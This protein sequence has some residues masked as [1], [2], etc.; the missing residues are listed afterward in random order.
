LYRTPE[1]SNSN[2]TPLPSTPL[3]SATITFIIHL[4]YCRYNAPKMLL[5]MPAL[6]SGMNTDFGVVV[7][8]VVVIGSFSYSVAIIRHASY[9]LHARS[10]HTSV[11]VTH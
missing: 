9:L 1:P 4:F 2:S 10:A 5:F 7:V 6:C 8:V 3:P 11:L